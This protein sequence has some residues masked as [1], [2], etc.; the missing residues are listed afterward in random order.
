MQAKGKSGEKSVSYNDAVEE[1]LCFGWIDSVI[2]HLD[3]LHRIQRFS[4]RKTNSG[5]SQ[6]NQE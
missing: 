6:G 4:P 2:K 1:A 3:P 5:Y